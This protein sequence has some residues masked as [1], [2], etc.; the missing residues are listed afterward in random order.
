[1][2]NRWNYSLKLYEN[3]IS[4]PTSIDAEQEDSHLDPRRGIC[5]AALQLQSITI[6][7]II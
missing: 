1:M 5:S 6:T 2:D 7:E 4:S 3:G